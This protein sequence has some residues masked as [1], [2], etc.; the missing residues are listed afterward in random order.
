MISQKDICSSLKRN[1]YSYTGFMKREQTWIVELNILPKNKLLLELLL[2]ELLIF[3]PD[4]P[5]CKT[6]K[7]LKIK[8]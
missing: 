1:F 4:L 7:E 6:D 8:H 2:G 5:I 3:K